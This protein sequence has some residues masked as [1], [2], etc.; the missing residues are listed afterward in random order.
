MW[1]AC[2]AHRIRLQ[3]VHVFVFVLVQRKVR[4]HTHT[5]TP[6][7]LITFTGA[8]WTWLYVCCVCALMCVPH[9]VDRCQM[10]LCVLTI[11]KH[12]EHNYMA[13]SI[14]SAEFIAQRNIFSNLQPGHII[15]LCAFCLERNTWLLTTQIQTILL[16][17]FVVLPHFKIQS[18]V[19]GSWI[20]SENNRLWNCIHCGEAYS[21]PVRIQLNQINRSMVCP[22]KRTIIVWTK[23][24]F[25]LV[26]EHFPFF[27]HVQYTIMHFAE[28]THIRCDCIFFV[29]PEEK[30]KQMTFDAIAQSHIHSSRT[31]FF[32][33]SNRSIGANLQIRGQR[34]II[35]SS[36]E[37]KLLS[38][39]DTVK[40]KCEKKSAGEV[41][42]LISCPRL[43][44]A[45]C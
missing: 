33:H 30:C 34:W 6:L 5:H 27:S 36:I 41:I 35:S 13:N 32:N 45:L 24:F 20:I 12:A 1:W 14:E 42:D 38:T 8:E 40:K 29:V 19:S 31:H 7:H 15:Y 23:H 11:Y 3:F 39:N 26:L 9:K 22:C 16:S 18:L 10:Y 25:R 21:N 37:I 44:W 43:T 28:S 4:T 17:Q 2:V